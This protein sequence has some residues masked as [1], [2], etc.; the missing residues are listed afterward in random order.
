MLKSWIIPAC[1]IMKGTVKVEAKTLAKAIEIARDETGVIPIPDNGEFLDGSWEVDCEDEGFIRD[2]YNDG[3]QDDDTAHSDVERLRETI[4]EFLARTYGIEYV[5]GPESTV[6]LYSG[7]IEE[8]SAFRLLIVADMENLTIK[9]FAGDILYRK[10][11]FASADDMIG[12][13]EDASIDS[14]LPAGMKK[15][16]EEWTAWIDA[17]VRK[18]RTGSG[19]Y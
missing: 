8:N 9:S 13:L 19:Q 6:C 2:F 16:P 10:L 12:E 7:E 17:W 11:E 5:F 3:Q 1:W 15:H 18:N 4:R 14:L